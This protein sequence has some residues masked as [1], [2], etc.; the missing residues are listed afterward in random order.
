MV[1]PQT[2]RNGIVAI[3]A[4]TTRADEAWNGNSAGTNDDVPGLG[5]AAFAEPQRATKRHNTKKLRIAL[6][7]INK[8]VLTWLKGGTMVA[9][10]DL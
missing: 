1:G 2:T 4:R 3:D 7:P 9:N 6:S 8:A 10:I 5:V